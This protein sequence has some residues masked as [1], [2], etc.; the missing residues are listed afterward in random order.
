MKYWYYE[1]CY[2]HYYALSNA[3]GEF[4]WYRFS[5]GG[6][7]AV[8]SSEIDTMKPRPIMRGCLPKV[9]REKAFLL[10]HGDA[11]LESLV[12]QNKL[13][14]SVQDTL[15]LAVFGLGRPINDLYEL[16][17]AQ[18]QSGVQR[19]WKANGELVEQHNGGILRISHLTNLR[20]RDFDG[21]YGQ[22]YR[23]EGFRW[24]PN[25]CFYLFEERDGVHKVRYELKDDGSAEAKMVRFDVLGYPTAVPDADVP[26]VVR[27]KRFMLEHGL[28]WLRDRN[29]VFD[30]PL[31]RQDL[32]LLASYLNRPISYWQIRYDSTL[33]GWIISERYLV[34]RCN[35]EIVST[36][37]FLVDK[38]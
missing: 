1:D 25:V 35:D 27:A 8:S 21:S 19:R 23:V 26:L 12:E 10:E 5:A 20:P 36:G 16:P 24:E 32:I 33:D 9:L 7:E 15:E 2:L 6:H 3:V 4:S 29:P 31:G 17:E 30:G 34:R 11:W 38:I 13:V 18:L 37:G 28:S 22:F 14:L